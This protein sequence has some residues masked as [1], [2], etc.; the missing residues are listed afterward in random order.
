M[1]TQSNW[2]LLICSAEDLA[3]PELVSLFTD[4][5]GVTSVKRKGSSPETLA[6]FCARFGVSEQAQRLELPR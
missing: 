2:G 6:S 4:S 3:D 1:E 5:A